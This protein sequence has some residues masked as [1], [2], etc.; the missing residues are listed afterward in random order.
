MFLDNCPGF[1]Y[2]KGVGEYADSKCDKASDTKCLGSTLLK[3]ML[4]EVK[5]FCDP[6]VRNSCCQGSNQQ[7]IYRM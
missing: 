5:D 3:T 4:S 6:A 2:N 7:V 1:N